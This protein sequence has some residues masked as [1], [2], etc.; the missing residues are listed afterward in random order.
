[1]AFWQG[2][3]AGLAWLLKSRGLMDVVLT[4]MEADAITLGKL[5]RWAG[6]IETLDQPDGTVPHND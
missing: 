6:I 1:M 3:S 2:C 5:G 4:A